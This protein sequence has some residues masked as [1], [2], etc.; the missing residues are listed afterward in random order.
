M[1]KVAVLRPDNTRI[2][3]AITYL[4]SLD[5]TPI[6]DPMLTICPTGKRPRQ[7]EFCVFTSKTGVELAVEHGWQ[8]DEE[9][10][11]AVGRHTAAAL[12][13][14]GYSVDVIPSTFTSTGLVEE[15]TDVVEGE[16]VEIARS[17][18]G[19]DVLIQ[20][21]KEAGADVHE[22]HL[23]YLE[24]PSTAGRSVSL[25]VEGELDGILFSSP[26]TVDHFFGIAAERDATGPLQRA[27]AETVIGAIGEPT[28]RAVRK[29][30]ASVDV[31]PD[32]ASFNRFA[33]TTV[34]RI[35]EI[36]Q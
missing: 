18:H 35:R 1:P 29:N 11:C 9:T 28:A 31:L 2:D 22:T 14:Y 27:A 10:V 6:S 17:A 33:R 3:E 34:N 7:A 5:V 32:Q 16:T 26:K 25:A 12:R 23:Y 4:Q 15:L 21:L 19:S 13:D 36:Q 30:G 20:G 24:Q 8:S